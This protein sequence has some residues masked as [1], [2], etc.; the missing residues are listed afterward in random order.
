MSNANLRC[1]LIDHGQCRKRG[2]A[3]EADGKHTIIG[4]GGKSNTGNIQRDRCCA[5]KT[6]FDIV[7]GRIDAEIASGFAKLHIAEQ[8]RPVFDGDVNRRRIRRS[9][10]E[11]QLGFWRI[12]D[13]IINQHQ[14]LQ[15]VRTNQA[16]RGDGVSF[17]R[18]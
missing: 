3:G 13:P 1:A 7:T 18:F 16:G 6:D 5:C 15:I 11:A 4:V 8:D 12:S 9:V 2:V 14:R 17:V 10:H